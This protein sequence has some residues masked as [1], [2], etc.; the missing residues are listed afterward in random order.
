MHIM[1]ILLAC[2]WLHGMLRVGE[3][4]KYSWYASQCLCYFLSP[5]CSDSHIRLAHLF[6]NHEC[7]LVTGIEDKVM[8]L[9]SLLAF[10]T[11]F[12]Y[13]LCLVL[14]LTGPPVDP[15]FLPKWLLSWFQLR[16]SR[17]RIHIA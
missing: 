11:P 2:S 4:K 9:L 15:G 17:Y 14:F 13:L 1:Y 3:A 16:I 7:R 10:R 8:S 6:V 12:A 5:R